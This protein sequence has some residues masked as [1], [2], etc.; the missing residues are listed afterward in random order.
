[1][2]TGINNSNPRRGGFIGLKCLHQ[3]VLLVG[4][5]LITLTDQECGGLVNG[6]VINIDWKI[7]DET[8]TELYSRLEGKVG[9]VIK[10]NWDPTQRE[11]NVYY[12]PSGSCVVRD[13][14]IY[15]GDTPGLEYTITKEDE[16]K[17]LFF[18]C[19]IDNHC[20]LG[21]HVTVH[22]SGSRSP[23]K[24]LNLD[25][26]IPPEGTDLYS[27]LD[28]QVGDIVVFDWNPEEGSLP[29]IGGDGT[30]GDST[31]VSRAGTNGTNMFKHNVYLEPSGT[32]RDRSNEQFVG[33]TPGVSFE[34]K[35]VHQGE[36]LFFVCHVD[37]HCDRGLH[38]TVH[39]SGADIGGDPVPPSDGSGE[40]PTDTDAVGDGG[41]IV[42]VSS[43]YLIVGIVGGAIT[44]IF[45]L[46]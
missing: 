27:R 20:S 16:G 2:K 38:V 19:H 6:E 24:F 41:N 31:A 28:A 30:D 23:I 45:Q 1:M 34:I 12:E 7:P 43:L 32:C 3:L 44:M 33:D 22:V 11:H 40:D 18:V 14:E 21:T 15:L 13:N 5:F 46:I 39:V 8:R 25:W 29:A 37:D 36:P 9:D 26:R 4:V 35:K 17:P 42:A 10:F